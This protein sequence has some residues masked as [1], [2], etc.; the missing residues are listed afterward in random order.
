[1]AG[2]VTAAMRRLLRSRGRG[3]RGSPKGGPH[4]PRGSTAARQEVNPARGAHIHDEP[5]VW[6][7]GAGRAAPVRTEHSSPALE[8][9]G[10][11]LGPGPG[12]SKGPGA[13]GGTG[14]TDRRCEDSLS[15]KKQQ[16]PSVGCPCHSASFP[17]FRRPRKICLIK[18]ELLALPQHASRVSIQGPPRDAGEATAALPGGPK[19]SEPTPSSGRAPQPR[20]GGA[21]GCSHVP[22]WRP[23]SQTRSPARGPLGRVLTAAPLPHRARCPGHERGKQRGE[24]IPTGDG[25][26]AAGEM[27]CGAGQHG[28]GGQSCFPAIGASANPDCAAAVG[29]AERPEGRVCT[30]APTRGGSQGPHASGLAAP[31]LDVK[32]CD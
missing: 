20:P 13:G 31:T 5:A 8:A 16:F 2:A 21:A 29:G 7:G 17:A 19:G 27:L 3:S 24:A 6:A 12:G 22:W 1:M 9:L 18:G 15:V 25:A 14:G 23:A 4:V 11:A 32:S 30:Q 10:G 28:P 26:H